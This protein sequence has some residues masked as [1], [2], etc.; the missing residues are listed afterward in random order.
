MVNIIFN[1]N[2]EVVDLNFGINI[3]FFNIINNKDGLGNLYKKG[4]FVHISP[5]KTTF[6]CVVSKI[7]LQIHL[8]EFCRQDCPNII[9][10]KN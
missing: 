6:T 7:V 5:R 10:Q 4:K 2:K 3:Y 1:N 8:H 9:H